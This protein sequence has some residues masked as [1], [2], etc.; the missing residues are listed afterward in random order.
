MIKSYKSKQLQKVSQGDLSKIPPQFA[1]IIQAILNAL[2]TATCINDFDL[3]GKRL[4]PYKNKIPK[5]WSL[6]VSGNYR[7][8]FEWNEEEENAYNVDYLDPH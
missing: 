4:H 1:K 5:T 7:I 6:D 3:P 8:T 2:D